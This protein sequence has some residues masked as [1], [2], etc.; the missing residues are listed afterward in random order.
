MQLWGGGCHARLLGSW[1]NVAALALTACALL[2][3][4]FLCVCAEAPGSPDDSG[5]EMMHWRS[6]D[7]HD[8][9]L[10]HDPLLSLLPENVQPAKR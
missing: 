10:P 3:L 4:T 5:F 6:N 8:L 9:E 1:P 7:L 2:V